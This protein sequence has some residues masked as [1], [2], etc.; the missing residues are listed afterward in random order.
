M[1]VAPC[2]I[3]NV[4]FNPPVISIVG[5]VKESTLAKL[6]DILPRLTT[7]SVRGR[8][9][10][11]TFGPST[12]YVNV[13]PPNVAVMDM[14]SLFADEVAQLSIIVAVLD[15]LE[16]EGG[17]TMT[18]THAASYDYTDHYSLFFTKRPPRM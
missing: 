7:N 3:V 8:R 13:N 15:C 17:W 2:L 4:S 10:P 5:P 1:A 9:K 12:E 11:P 16:D 6:N 14:G 18:D